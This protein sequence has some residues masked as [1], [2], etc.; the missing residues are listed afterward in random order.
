[1][2][3]E[4]RWKIIKNFY[5]S[6]ADFEKNCPYAFLLD[7]YL[8]SLIPTNRN[9]TF[10]GGNKDGESYTAIYEI[11]DP[12]GLYSLEVTCN[13]SNKDR[14]QYSFKKMNG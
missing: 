12:N 1:M 3:I 8:Q 13:V 2:S 5:L 4:G 14:Y 11:H 10:I 6:P 7:G 9:Y